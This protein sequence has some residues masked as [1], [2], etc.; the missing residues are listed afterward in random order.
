MSISSTQK[1]SDVKSYIA[2]V[3]TGEDVEGILAGLSDHNLFPSDISWLPAEVEADYFLRQKGISPISV[4]DLLNVDDRKRI[5]LDALEWSNCWLDEIPL[6]NEIVSFGSGCS[7]SDL[8]SHNIYN[9]FDDLF[10]LIVLLEKVIKEIKPKTFVVSFNRP[11]KILGLDH[12]NEFYLNQITKLMA[13]KFSIELL[14]IDTSKIGTNDTS[15]IL[16]DNKSK[17]DE[18]NIYS[19]ALSKIIGYY[20]SSTSYSP[21]DSNTKQR[22]EGKKFW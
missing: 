12:S 7:L 5:F 10:Y 17:M 3:E 16:T 15:L 11:E 22:L 21:I 18:L 8:V 2:L 6:K 9:L 20:N 14:E 13:K 4:T 19:K 1:L